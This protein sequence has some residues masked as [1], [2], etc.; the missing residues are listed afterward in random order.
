MSRPRVHE[1][2]PP[3]TCTIVPSLAEALFKYELAKDD[4]Q[5]GRMLARRHM[6]CETAPVP[7]IPPGAPGIAGK[8][9]A[10]ESPRGT[11]R[12]SISD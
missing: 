3:A 2:S 8:A 1:Q 9:I 5:E 11:M 10:P 12:S 4:R 6:T 7:T